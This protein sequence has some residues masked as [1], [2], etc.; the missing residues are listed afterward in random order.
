MLKTTILPFTFLLAFLTMPFYREE[1][2][3][4]V[5]Q[6][7]VLKLKN[8][9]TCTP[10]RSTLALILAQNDIPL[11]PGSGSYVWKIN[12]SND[13]AQIY[14]NQGVNT[15]FGFHIIESLASFKKAA[16][17]DPENPMVH[18]AQA[19]AY[20]PNINDVAYNTSPDAIAAVRKAVS[21]INKASPVD[22]DLIRVMEVRYSEDTTKSR[23]E[24]NQAYTDAMAKLYE[25]HPQSPDV[26][27]LY[28]DAMMLQHPWDLWKVN[29]TPR[30]WTPRIREVLEKGLAINEQH[31]GLNHYYIHVMEPSPTP[32]KAKASADRLG[33]I[34]PGL[35]HLVHMPSHIYL[36][37]GEFEK[38]TSINRQAVDKFREY[39]KMF[40]AV[41]ESTFLY[42]WHNQHMLVN[43]AMHAGKYKTS[44]DA[45]NE[46][47]NAIDSGTLA[48]APPM[49]SL[50]QYVHMAP[51]L[52]NVR[53]EQWDS[54]MN[55]PK[56]HEKLI[57]ANIIY[58]FGK[59]FAQA[60]KGDIGSAM[61]SAVAMEELMKN[62]DLKLP[63]SP[64][65]SAI[66]GAVAANELLRGVI[67]MKDNK[68]DEAIKRL[69]KAAE[70]EKNMVYNEPRDWFL[71]PHQYL[72]TAYLKKKD[73]KKAEQIYNRDL[74]I[75]ANNIWSLYRLQEVKLRQGKKK[76]PVMQAF[77]KYSEGSDVNFAQLDY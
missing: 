45:A 39:G 16:K 51:V 5:D 14:F 43:C 50:I 61:Q 35:A 9:I 7:R 47:H 20:G 58:H 57:Y 36:R 46:L 25:K 54:L 27:A 40:P 69:S 17:F 29:G 71:N 33:A 26:L 19:L 28:A 63:M 13:S 66:E 60:S 24:L 55:M 52:I 56:P 64:F 75:N 23:E 77:K 22:Q 6:I 70:V 59:G 62:D 42:Y 11:L 49:G 8:A 65:S 67:A 34:T 12:T 3:T 1:K 18:W 73:Y 30:P 76:A 32:E 72:G 2:L 74:K 4:A 37:T 10:D 15:Y 41:N 48:M 53:F 68:L 31:P 38:G 21:L 44:I